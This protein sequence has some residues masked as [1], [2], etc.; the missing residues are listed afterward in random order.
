MRFRTTAGGGLKVIV[1][2]ATAEGV[3]YG[4]QTVKQLI[5]GRWRPTAVLHACEYSWTGRR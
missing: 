5:E 1:G 4:A 3:F 2:F